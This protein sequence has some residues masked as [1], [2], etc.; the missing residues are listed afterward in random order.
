MAGLYE[1]VEEAGFHKVA[2]GYVFQTSSCWMIGPR[3]RYFVNEAQK[4]AIA[5]CL[6]ETLRRLKPFVLVAA[7]LIPS[8]IFGGTLWLALHDHTL[9]VVVTSADGERVTSDRSIGYSGG[10]G[11]LAGA[12]G[13]KVIFQVS[14]P[15]GQ[16]TALTETFVDADGKRGVPTVIPFGPG[17][18]TVRT[19]DASGRIVNSAGVV[20]LS[21]STHA[22]IYLDAALLGLAT[23]VPYLALIHLYSLR[24]LR[25]LIAGLPRVSERIPAREASRSFARSASLKLLVLM[26]IGG[27]ASCVGNGM[28]ILDAALEGRPLTYLPISWIALCLS[29]LATARFAYLVRLRAKL[30]REEARFPAVFG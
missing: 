19:A 25:P 11:E 1:G 13:T 26:A 4:L 2:G 21:G 12:S 9:R 5:A 29:A 22:A 8:I 23:F 17:G 3:R 16:D 20:V 28:L 14:A 18:V 6:R 10:A 7:V 27:A 24:R 30:R 15:P